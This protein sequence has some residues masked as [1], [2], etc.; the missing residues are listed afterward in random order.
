[1][2]IFS[3]PKGNGNL[4]H[5]HMQEHSKV[6]GSFSKLNSTPTVYSREGNLTPQNFSSVLVP[7]LISKSTIK[8]KKTLSLTLVSPFQKVQ[9]Q[10]PLK[11]KQKIT[12]RRLNSH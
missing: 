11:N 5:Y 4:H 12:T 2:N 1:M 3:L 9:D 8:Q 7:I 10:G 6:P